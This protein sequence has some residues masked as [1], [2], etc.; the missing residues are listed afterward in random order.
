M[1]RPEKGENTGV[2]KSSSIAIL[3]SVTCSGRKLTSRTGSILNPAHC[4]AVG[5]NVP[6]AAFVASAGCSATGLTIF[7]TMA[8]PSKT[9]AAAMT[10][11]ASCHHSEEERRGGGAIASMTLAG[12]GA[13]GRDTRR[14]RKTS[15]RPT[16]GRIRRGFDE[17]HDVV[18]LRYRGAPAERSVKFSGPTRS[19]PVFSYT[20]LKPS[21]QTSATA[22]IVTL[23]KILMKY[24]E[25]SHP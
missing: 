1:T 9:S 8:R 15:V 25:G 12:N 2:V 4:A 23:L 16:H 14:C 5:R 6:G 7:G 19:I 17:G 11:I 21:D 20:C 18:T 13:G 10:T 24:L 3:P 22:I